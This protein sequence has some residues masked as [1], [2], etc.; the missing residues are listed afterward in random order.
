MN[1]YVELIRNQVHEIKFKEFNLF[2]V[3]KKKVMKLNIYIYVYIG[4]IFP[5]I[6]RNYK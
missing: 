3:L 4:F 6:Y 5:F 2:K 1:K